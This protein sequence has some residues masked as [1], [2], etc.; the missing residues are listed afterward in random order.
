MLTV[1]TCLGRGALRWMLSIYRS[2]FKDVPSEGHTT[3]SN[4]GSYSQNMPDIASRILTNAFT[5]LA[6]AQRLIL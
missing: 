5:T 3:G 1:K 4:L 6:L 2:H